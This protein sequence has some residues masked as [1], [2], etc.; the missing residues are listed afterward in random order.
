MLTMHQTVHNRKRI[1]AALS[2]LRYII[3]VCLVYFIHVKSKICNTNNSYYYSYSIQTFKQ[4]FGKLS[5]LVKLVVSCS[6]STN[7]SYMYCILIQQI[8]HVC[9][10]KFSHILINIIIVPKVPTSWKNRSYCG[11]LTFLLHYNK[12]QLEESHVNLN[13]R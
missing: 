8:Y 10:T 7:L 1:L 9:N 11:L 13:I 5:K 3:A 4:K 12:S 6:V 2:L